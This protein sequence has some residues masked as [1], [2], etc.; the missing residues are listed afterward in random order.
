MADYTRR[1]LRLFQQYLHFVRG[2]I[3]LALSNFVLRDGPWPMK[4][5]NSWIC[6]STELLMKKHSPLCV[7]CLESSEETD[8]EWPLSKSDDL[9]E[10]EASQYAHLIPGV[11][12]Q[13]D[14]DVYE[15]FGDDG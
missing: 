9:D 7:D 14:D 1:G 4:G 2:A 13:P 3:G 5:V 10:W 15:W 8:A 6:P 12:L 11:D